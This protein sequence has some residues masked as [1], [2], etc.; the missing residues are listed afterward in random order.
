MIRCVITCDLWL[1]GDADIE[2]TQEAAR[3]LA[4]AVRDTDTSLVNGGPMAHML[5]SVE[6]RR[7]DDE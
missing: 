5:K 6:V 7:A 3:K 2:I 4:A 1:V